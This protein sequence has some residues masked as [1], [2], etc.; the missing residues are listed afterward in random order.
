M[1]TTE[2]TR[3]RRS[4]QDMR[5]ASKGQLGLVTI[6]PQCCRGGGIRGEGQAG[7]VRGRRQAD[8]AGTARPGQY[9]ETRAIRRLYAAKPRSR[10]PR[11]PSRALR[12][13]EST[14][15]TAVG[16][17]SAAGGSGGSSP[18]ELMRRLV[19]VEAGADGDLERDAQGGG[20]GH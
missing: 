16:A 10:G 12:S 4:V 17:R 18:R 9:G 13:R 20:A 15:S 19:P 1:T 6:R 3:T 7:S 14:A 8:R 2:R 5:A 11:G